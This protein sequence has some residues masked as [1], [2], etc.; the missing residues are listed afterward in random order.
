MIDSSCIQTVPTWVVSLISA[1]LGAGVGGLASYL[2]SYALEKKK[3]T[4]SAAILRKDE[5]YSP[6]YDGLASLIEE[7]KSDDGWARIPKI[8]ALATW[9]ELSGRSGGLELPEAFV[10][11][12]DHFVRLSD[13]YVDAH[14]RLVDQ[15]MDAFPDEHLGRE[16]WGIARLLAGRMLLGFQRKDYEVI[17]YIRKQAPRPSPDLLQY[18]TPNRFAEARTVIESLSAWTPTKQFH[19]KYVKELYSLRDELAKRIRRIAERYQRA[20]PDL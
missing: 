3:W 20:A 18:W 8:K 7:L 17:D 15:I 19:D 12:L 16:D 11:R 6:V 10:R 14:R 9:R 4:A 1:L 13:K 5:V 2:G